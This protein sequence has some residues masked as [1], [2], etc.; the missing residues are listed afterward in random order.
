[1]KRKPPLM[2]LAR[3]GWNSSAGLALRLYSEQLVQAA[4]PFWK[5]P[6]NAIQTDA[7]SRRR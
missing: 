7:A 1:M 5:L 2:S 4:V 6:N 3:S